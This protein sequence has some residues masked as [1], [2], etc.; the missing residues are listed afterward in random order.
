[1][2]HF[3]QNEKESKANF[4]QPYLNITQIYYQITQ[5]TLL[6]TVSRKIRTYFELYKNKN[7]TFL[8]WLTNDE[9]M[10]GEIFITLN[11]LLEKKKDFN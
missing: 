10:L 7:V 4:T 1:M 2:P 3:I 9:A 11:Y 5:L 6:A 8:N